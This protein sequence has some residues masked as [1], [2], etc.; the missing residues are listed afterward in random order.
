MFPGVLSD[1]ATMNVLPFDADAGRVFVDLRRSGVRVDTMDLRIGS[2]A[3]VRGFVVLTRNA[4]DF[5]RIPGLR[6]EDWT[7]PRRPK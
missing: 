1:F 6:V 7:S 2:I 5:G 4:V 3:L